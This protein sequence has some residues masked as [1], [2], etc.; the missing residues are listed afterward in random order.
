MTPADFLA[1]RKRLGF[2]RAAAASALGLSE[3]RLIDYER[4]RTRGRETEAPIP[5]VVELACAAVAAG[6]R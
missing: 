3:S 1:W 2:S 5:R 6:L 4:G